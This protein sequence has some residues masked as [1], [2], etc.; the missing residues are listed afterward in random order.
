MI[1]FAAVLG[2]ILFFLFPP[3]PLLAGDAPSA[4]AEEAA[5][6]EAAPPFIPLL[7]LI[8]AVERGEIPWTPDWPPEIPPDAFAVPAGR[9]V[10]IT[11]STEGGEY[12]LRR[13]SRGLLEEFPLLLDGAFVQARVRFG[14]GGE[15]LMFSIASE[16]ERVVEFQPVPPGEPSLARFSVG[17][18][19]W[20][21]A[22]QYAGEGYTETWYDGEGGFQGFFQTGLGEGRIIS[23]EGI[24][25]SGEVRGR[26]YYDGFGNVSEIDGEPGVFSALYTGLNRPR[27]WEFRPAGGD[28][29][30]AGEGEAGDTAPAETARRYV[31]QWDERGLLVR[32]SG[33]AE[34]EDGEEYRYD[35]SLDSRGNWTERRERR[36]IRRFGAL[37]AGPGPVIRRRIEYG[38]R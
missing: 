18:E 8:L 36:M 7:P 22:G 13:N 16:P 24:S 32:L 29:P 19:T 12:R 34:G 9:P 1:R 20:F 2:A 6:E 25:S 3:S 35:Y 21:V 27:Y 33:G 11:L 15:I 30:G 28:A 31:L 26:Y 4:G 23:R 38:G 10:S 37:A 17:E 14:P 5:A